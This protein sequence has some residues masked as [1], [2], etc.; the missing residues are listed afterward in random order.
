VSQT[1][2]V[3]IK[4]FE[5]QQRDDALGHTVNID[6]IRAIVKILGRPVFSEKVISVE[7]E[8]PTNMGIKF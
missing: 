2:I 1:N 7:F 4:I 3:F 5:N 6:R 8:S